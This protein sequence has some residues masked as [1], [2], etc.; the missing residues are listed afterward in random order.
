MTTKN[1]IRSKQFLFNTSHTN[2]NSQTIRE[3]DHIEEDNEDE[4]H[5]QGLKYQINEN[6][7]NQENNEKS[8]LKYD[9][10]DENNDKESIPIQEDEH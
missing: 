6:I 1:K 8:N 5:N 7:E 2:F 10:Q 9:S 3:N 4:D